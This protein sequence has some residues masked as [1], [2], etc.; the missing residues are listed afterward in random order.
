MRGRDRRRHRDVLTARE[1]TGRD[2]R[3]ERA[4]RIDRAEIER[5]NDDIFR[6]HTRLT[7]DEIHDRAHDG[8]VGSVGI[9]FPRQTLDLHIDEHSGA[10]F[11]R[12]AERRNVGIR[13]SQRRKRLLE[14]R[15]GP[16]DVRVVV[17]YQLRVGGAAHIE[18]DAVRTQIASPRERRDGVFGEGAR[19]ASM[20]QYE[21]T[22]THDAPAYGSGE[23]EHVPLHGPKLLV[24][25]LAAT[26][27][28]P[29]A[30]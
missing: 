25:P 20:P 12:L 9:R 23:R 22:G 14:Y 16:V 8:A 19:S 2:V 28:V 10:R 1:P 21:R 18:F 17:Y 27:F 7:A 5:R 11:E 3:R 29:L 13:V 6:G 26:R 15:D 24:N 30:C 4:T